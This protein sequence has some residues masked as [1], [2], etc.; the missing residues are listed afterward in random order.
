MEGLTNVEKYGTELNSNINGYEKIY[1]TNDPTSDLGVWC[2]RGTNYGVS[3]NYKYG[4]C[5]KPINPSNISTIAS[6][7]SS[8]NLIAG[9]QYIE[10][11]KRKD[12][13]IRFNFNHYAGVI[14]NFKIHYEDGTSE[15]IRESVDNNKIEPLVII[16]GNPHTSSTSYYY[17]NTVGIIETGGS[18]GTNVGSAM[19]NILFKPKQNI[20]GVSFDLSHNF[21]GNYN[22]IYIN[23]YKNFD[24]SITP[25][26]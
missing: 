12:S 20:V 22:S 9:N 21:S 23:E 7:A 19:L 2:T 8:T 3:Y 6:R 11:T 1:T 13:W 16:S 5:L 26:K 18:T 4:A 25:V 10:F 14:S 24:L 17:T 15:S